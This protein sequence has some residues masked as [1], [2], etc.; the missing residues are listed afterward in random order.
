MPSTLSLQKISF[1]STLLNPVIQ[2]APLIL[3]IGCT[4]SGPVSQPQLSSSSSRIEKPPQAEPI[5]SPVVHE[6]KAVAKINRPGPIPTRPLNVLAECRF[7]DETG[8]SGNLTLTIDQATV[9][10]FEAAVNVPKRGVCQFSLKNFRQTK[11]LPNVELSHLSD[12]CIVRVWE[13]GSRVT[14]AFQQC[15][16]MC[17]GKA[18]EHLWPILADTQDGSCA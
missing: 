15:R 12:P 3:L 11:A 10:A 9:Q 18:W 17:S 13:Q 14:V 7:R 16:K 6:R 5:P 8:Y 2:T 4:T 1:F